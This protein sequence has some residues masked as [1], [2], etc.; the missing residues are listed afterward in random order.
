MK[1]VRSERRIRFD[2]GSLVL[3]GALGLP[4]EAGHPVPGAVLC[5]PHPLYGGT[6]DNAVVL[7]VA[8]ALTARG[9]AV[10]RFNFR[11]VGG[12]AGGHE[13]GEAEAADVGA[14]LEA[15]ASRPEVD[16][17][18]LGVAGYSFGAAMGLRA[19]CVDPRVRAVVLVAPPVAAFPMPEGAFCTVPKLVI[20]GT[21][22]E[23]CPGSCRET[24]FEAAAGPKR[25]V[26]IAGADHFF[27]GRAGEVGGA[28]A[29]FLE[30]HLVGWTA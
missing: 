14:A 26:E 28:A 22:D 25:W 5:H 9:L 15:L 18:R 13:G 4:P 29:S 24:W 16:A 30:E 21:R 11:G 6:M 27:G 2:C 17:A 23:Y 12:S 8:E 7:A 20:A 10:L 3:E 19:A 1:D